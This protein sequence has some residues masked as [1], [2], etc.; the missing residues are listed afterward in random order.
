MKIKDLLKNYGNSNPE[1]HTKKVGRFSATDLYGIIHG[2]TTPKQFLEGRVMD[3]KGSINCHRGEVVEIGAKL[4]FERS[5]AEFDTQV[6]DVIIV[7]GIEYVAVA[8]FTFKKDGIPY[9]ILECKS[10]ENFNGL[11]AHNLHQLELQYRIFK[12]PIYIGYF[13]FIRG[14]HGNVFTELGSYKYKPSDKL[15]LIIQ[16]RCWDF[17]EELKIYSASTHSSGSN[18]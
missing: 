7:D 4:L 14:E 8:D 10:P 12:L 6:K 5:G 3:E 16:T 17:N 1:K 2:Y 15:W 13:D 18:K 11:K 9:K